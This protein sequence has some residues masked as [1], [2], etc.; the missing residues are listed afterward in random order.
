MSLDFEEFLEYFTVEES[1]ANEK[2]LKVR[3]YP[4]TDLLKN[5]NVDTVSEKLEDEFFDDPNF[6]LAK[7]KIFIRK[8]GSKVVRQDSYT[9]HFGCHVYQEVDHV[10]TGDYSSVIQYGFERRRVTLSNGHLLDMYL[11]TI[12]DPI[13]YE[14][15]SIR[16]PLENFDKQSILEAFCEVIRELKCVLDGVVPFAFSKFMYFLQCSNKYELFDNVFSSLEPVHELIA[17]N[18]EKLLEQNKDDSNKNLRKMRSIYLWTMRMQLDQIQIMF[19]RKLFEEDECY[20]LL[21]DARDSVMNGK[22]QLVG[23]DP[24]E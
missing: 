2:F 21:K 13:V 15:I 19:E 22:V 12:T 4:T 11:D 10:L 14:V 9:L 3:L 23:C 20:A 6:A 8:R 24:C 1:A 17:V 5:V 16:K 18:V 7:Q